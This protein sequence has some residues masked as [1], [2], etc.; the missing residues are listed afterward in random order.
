VLHFTRTTI[1]KLSLYLKEFM[2][3]VLQKTFFLPACLQG[4]YPAKK[5]KHLLIDFSHTGLSGY[6]KWMDGWT[7]F[8]IFKQT[9]V[10]LLFCFLSLCGSTIH[11]NPCCSLVWQ[12][13]D[14]PV[15]GHYS[16]RF[17]F[18]PQCLFKETQGVHE[19]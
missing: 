12:F 5:G 3:S 4:I 17:S 2:K 9:F 11:I 8:A 13:A 16:K 18:F 6:S 1:H 7:Q 14:T 15:K 10:S 19:L